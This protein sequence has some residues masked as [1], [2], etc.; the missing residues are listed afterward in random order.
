MRRLGIFILYVLC[1]VLWGKAVLAAAEPWDLTVPPV[2]KHLTSAN[3]LPYPVAFSIEQDGEGY[4]WVATPGGLARWDG[5][6]LSVFRHDEKDEGSLPE[7]IVTHLHTDRQGRLWLSSASGIVSRFDAQSRKFV[8][9]RD[10]GSGVGRVLDLASD[11]K[12]GIWIAGRRGL[13][14]L[15]SK[16]GAWEIQEAADGLPSGEVTSVLVDGT[17]RVWAGSAQGLMRRSEANQSF[18]RVAMPTRTK[19]GKITSLFEDSRQVI[20]FGTGKGAV[21]TVDDEK[22]QLTFEPTMPLTGH[23]ISAIVEVRPGVLW[24]S[25]FGNGIRELRTSSFQTRHFQHNPSLTASL[26]D[27]SV[28]GL[29]VDKSGVIWASTQ[30]GVSYSIPANRQIMTIVPSPSKGLLGTDVRSLAATKNGRVWVGHRRGGIALLDPVANVVQVIPTGN[31]PGDLP[32]GTVQAIVD[33]GDGKLWVGL[34]SGLYRVDLASGQTTQ[35]MPLAN[36]DVR[37]LLLDKRGLWVTGSE[38]LALVASENEPPMLFRPSRDDPTSISDASGMALARDGKGRIWVGTQR[39][40]NLLEDE[41]TGKFRQIHPDMDNPDGLRSDVITS[42][43]SDS[44]GRLWLSTGSGIAIFDPALAGDPKFK[45]LSMEQGL[46]HDTVLSVIEGQDGK[47]FAGTGGGLAVIDPKDFSIRT[48]EPAQGAQIG[49]FWA[50]SAARLSD[51]TLALGGFGGMVVIRPGPLPEWNFKPPVVLTEVRVGRKVVAASGSIVIGPEN[52]G[53]SV[54]FAALDFTAPEKN[55]YTYRLI[56]SDKDWVAIQA[57]Q[58]FVRYANLSPGSYRLEVKG[59][60]GVGSMNADPVSLDILVMPA[61]HQT[62]WFRLLIALACLAALAGLMRGRKL[63]YLRRERE[64]T[65]QVAA[66]TSEVEAAMRRAVAGEEEARRAKEAA[67]SADQMKSR[68][69]AIIGHEIRTPLNGLLGMLQLL[70]PRSLEKGPRELLST[71]KE[72]GNNLRYLVESILEYGRSSVKDPEIVLSNVELHRLAADTL[73]LIRPQAQAKGLDLILQV[74]PQAPLWIRCDHIKLSRILINLLGNAVK[75][76][77]EGSVTADLC[78]HEQGDNLR[79]SV[80]VTDT[81]IGIA[82]DL[83]EAIFGDFVQGDDSIT[84]KYGGAGLGLA[85]SRRMAAQMG[86]SLSVDS[87]VGT[88]S[89]FQL[90]I[91]VEAAEPVLE[92]EVSEVQSSTPSLR[93]FVVDDDEIN[94]RVARQ[95]LLRL[96]HSPTCFNCGK[97]AIKALP[98]ADV[99]AILMDLRMPAMDGME[100]TRRIRQWEKGRQGRLRILAMTADLTKEVWRQ[101]EEAGMDGGI[102]KPVQLEKLKE[103]LDEI[104]LPDLPIYPRGHAL[105]KGFLRAQLE[106]LG[107]SEMI[108]LARLFQKSSRLMIAAMEAAALAGDNQAV[109]AQAHRM[110]SAAGPLGLADVA[111]KAGQVEADSRTASQEQLQ[112]LVVL[113]GKARRSGLEALGAAARRLGV[114]QDETTGAA[115][116]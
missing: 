47:M 74:R 88:G 5:L 39:G 90:D 114:D 101:C 84:R 11:D 102:S 62:W 17:G 71:A 59:S 50:N 46:P 70:D 91:H 27:N 76:T 8:S 109:E 72:A 111:D 9:Y 33:S 79:L 35:Y 24:V 96:G 38:G 112:E 80:A 92:A 93:V 85:I 51:G 98:G 89:K 4:I 106:I 25:E 37:A 45:R 23:Q 31:Q 83:R 60:N 7:N 26:G 43:G 29:L 18:Q 107:A 108:R 105:D 67:E 49:T 68:F 1:I 34:P 116:R 86:G 22:G 110:R 15:D 53:F 20:W 61:W 54:E 115:N 32:A 48:I 56:G 77:D 44:S 3:G 19:A 103:A 58:R 42:I 36:T 66:K 104:E 97:D 14:K 113:L 99:D 64:L 81:G 16:T 63:Y 87:K 13:A 41:K 95:L 10:N 82:D 65:L 52:R 21:G 94:L 40:L 69:L 28:S 75:F 57:R 30:G 73:A 78:V 55:R 100:T 2:F 12:G 6:R